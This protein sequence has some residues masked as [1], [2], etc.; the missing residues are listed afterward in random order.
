LVI[1]HRQV[2]ACGA[3]LAR[4]ASH[5][6]IPAARPRHGERQREGALFPF[7]MEDRFVRLRLNRTEAVHAAEVLSAVHGCF[8][9]PVPIMESRVTNAASLSSLQPS[10][11]LGRIG[12]TR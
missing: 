12:M 4:K 5:I 7:G 3:V 10:V 1:T 8:A 9:S 6:D 2:F 11:P